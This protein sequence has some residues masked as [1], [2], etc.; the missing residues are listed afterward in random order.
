MN[1]MMRGHDPKK[2]FFDFLF[3]EKTIMESSHM[4]ELAESVL[5]SGKRL[6]ML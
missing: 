4:D 5:K 2:S 3:K 1:A 6:N